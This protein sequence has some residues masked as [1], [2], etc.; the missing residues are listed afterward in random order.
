MFD[1]G[2]LD[3]LKLA[4]T[5]LLNL[6]SKGPSG[7]SELQLVHREGVVE[8]TAVEAM[9]VEAT[10]AA[11]AVLVV[12]AP[13]LEVV[14]DQ[15]P[16]SIQTL[17]LS[18]RLGLVSLANLFRMHLTVSLKELPRS[19]WRSILP[20]LASP[21]NLLLDLRAKGPS[22]E[23]E[24]QPV[25]QEVVVAMEVG[26]AMGV[27]V[28]M[29]AVMVAVVVAVVVKSEEV[30]LAP[31]PVLALPLLVVVVLERFRLL[32]WQGCLYMVPRELLS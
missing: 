22:G 12:V 28:V 16:L 8:A 24:F 19:L 20:A 23:S 5:F 18:L 27:V 29:V 21:R 6:I 30:H 25:R 26:V 1:R 32:I 17:P 4:R 15:D 10:V 31:P 3:L 7:E 14:Q 13:V 9:A 11:V 2:I